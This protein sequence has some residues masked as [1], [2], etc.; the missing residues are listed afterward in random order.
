MT[1]KAAGEEAPGESG[2]RTRVHSAM[3]SGAS[4][5]RAICSAG[6]CGSTSTSPLESEAADWGRRGTAPGVRTHTLF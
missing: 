6:G 4:A 2:A 3:Q 5:P 1:V